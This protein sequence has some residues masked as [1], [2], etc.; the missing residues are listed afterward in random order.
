[1]KLAIAV[2][3]LAMAAP[4]AAGPRT[5]V[6]SKQFTEG[7]ILG[8]IVTQVAAGAGADAEHRAQMG[9]TRILWTAL[10]SGAID[11]YVEYSGTLGEEI[12]PELGLPRGDLSAL[13]TALA[14]SGL[15]KTRRA[16]F[17]AKLGLTPT[18]LPN[19]ET[20]ATAA[21]GGQAERR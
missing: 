9:G 8:E 21:G 16:E 11:A 20:P 17:L 14:E 4:A 1:M 2:L 5:R 15:R 13:R 10:T 12:L 3:A 7:V 6:G 19:D 18:D